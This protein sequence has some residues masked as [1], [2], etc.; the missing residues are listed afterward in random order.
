M[1]GDIL[2][3]RSSAGSSQAV[4]VVRW[5]SIQDPDAYRIGVEVLGQRSSA[6]IVLRERTDTSRSASTHVAAS[7]AWP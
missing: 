4:G 3:I 7:A 5:L 1:V 6:I 2:G